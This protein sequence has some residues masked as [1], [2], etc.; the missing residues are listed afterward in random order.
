[1]GTVMRNL[2]VAFAHS[3]ISY[4][5][6]LKGISKVHINEVALGAELDVN[7]EVLAEP[8]QTV[9][10]MEGV[11]N[12]YEKLKELTRGQKI[13]A[14]GM[15]AFIHKLEISEPARERLLALTPAN[16]VGAAASL[17]RTI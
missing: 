16:Y 6:L 10:R 5:S 13:D 17:A 15:R 4:H 9:M 7:W 12:P 8:I 11:E 1:M 3:T 2:G 14:A